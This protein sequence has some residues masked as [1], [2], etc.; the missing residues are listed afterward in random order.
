MPAGLDSQEASHLV[1]RAH[2]RSP[3]WHRAANAQ[4]EEPAA[5]S[6]VAAR[7]RHFHEPQTQAERSRKAAAQHSTKDTVAM[8]PQASAQQGTPT[9]LPTRR[10]LVDAVTEE[11]NQQAA[12][13]PPPS[14]FTIE[15]PEPLAPQINQPATVAGDIANL[16][17]VIQQADR[18][19]D[20]LKQAVALLER[21]HAD[22]V[23]ILQ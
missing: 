11:L 9:I 19:L 23:S 5:L 22:T 17:G 21:H 15:Q 10:K 12:D 6:H 16:K 14:P 13:T 2:R 18:L 3:P 8:S 20:R 7:C 4:S 1:L